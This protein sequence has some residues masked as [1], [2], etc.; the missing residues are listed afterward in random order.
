MRMSKPASHIDKVIFIL[1]NIRHLQMRKVIFIL[2]NIR[3]LQMRK[4]HNTK[5]AAK[6]SNRFCIVF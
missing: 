4:H 1:I 3:H 2:I 6:L 5:A